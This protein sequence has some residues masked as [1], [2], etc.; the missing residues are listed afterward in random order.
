MKTRQ[1]VRG[2]FMWLAVCVFPGLIA[3]GQT[4]LAQTAGE[5]EIS[6]E[7]RATPET[8]VP[9]PAPQAGKSISNLTGRFSIRERGAPQREDVVVFNLGNKHINA[10]TGGVAQGAGMTFGLELTTA[11]LI[12]WVEF[13]LA[14]L[15]STR[16][17][18]RFDAG[19][20]IPVIGDEH[21]HAEIWVSYLRRTKDD[22]YGIGPRFPKDFQTNFDVEKRAVNATFY[23]DFTSRLQAGV[24]ARVA[25]SGTFNGEDDRDIPMDQLFSGNP[26]VV[27]LTRWAPGFQANTKI[28]SYGVYGEY[29]RRNKDQGLTKGFYLYGRFA[30][31]DG[32]NYD[33]NPVFQDYGW[34]EAELDGRAYVPLFSD[35]T[36]LAVRAFSELKSPKGGSQIPFYELSYLGGRAHL[37]GFPNYRFRGNNSLHFSGELR[38]TVWRRAENQGLD[39]FAFADVG[40]V[41]GDNRSKTDP[42]ITQ[43][44]DFASRN[45]RTGAGGGVQYRLSKSFACRVELGHSNERNL[46]YFSFSHGF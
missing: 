42:A 26:N 25:N 22:F 30:S 12:K 34:L 2:T 17:Y 39:V 8:S 37:R 1:V 33:N 46:V 31:A 3:T 10:I 14:A 28:L 45:W 13:R 40:Q 11:D 44:D 41:W 18:R 32:L 7:S 38:Q 21:T 16:L 9:P 15:T 20:Y 24:Y 43:N 35:R 29:D 27:P 23:R 19:A 36:S 4:C 6:E 5:G